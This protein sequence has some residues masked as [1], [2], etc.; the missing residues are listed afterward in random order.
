MKRLLVAL[1][2]AATL[3]VPVAATAT[4]DPEDDG[5]K[6]TICH[7]TA[8]DSNPY[9]FIEVDEAS[10]SPGHLDNADPGHKPTFWKSDGV[11]RGVPHSEGD[12]KDD[13]LAQSAADCEDFPQ[14]TTTETETTSPPTTTTTT[15]PQTTTTT[16]TAPPST[17]TSS[18]TTP[19]SSTSTPPPATSSTSPPPVDS[20]TP[21]GPS[22]GERRAPK[23]AFT[24]WEDVVPLA[25]FGLV[26]LTLGS[27]LFWLGNRSARER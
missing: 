15:P 4:P 20:S 17:S 1:A 18:T 23:L 22:Q 2:A 7:R 13:Y 25:L 16:S 5:H 6:V 10:L 3:A 12:P 21:P 9:V 14:T 24:G 19:P 8:S 11:F 26:L 27:G